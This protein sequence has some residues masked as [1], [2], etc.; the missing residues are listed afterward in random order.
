L[1][2]LRH[3]NIVA[4]VD[5]FYGA[6]QV[7]RAGAVVGSVRSRCERVRVCVS[8][9]ARLCMRACMRVLRVILCVCA[10]V[11]ACVRARGARRR[12][13]LCSGRRRAC[14]CT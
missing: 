5:V 1:R 3:R 9:C 11:F 7:Q 2:E 4:L 8:V 6:E 12:A 14:M 13:Y 10:C